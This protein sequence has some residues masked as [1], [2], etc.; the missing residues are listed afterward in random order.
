MYQ[1]PWLQVPSPAEVCQ[2][3][4]LYPDPKTII[5]EILQPV[6]KTDPRSK[7]RITSE[8]FLGGRLWKVHLHFQWPQKF[9]V[10]GQGDHCGRAIHYAYLSACQMFMHL[11]LLTG[12]G[13]MIDYKETLLEIQKMFKNDTVNHIIEF[14]SKHEVF[15]NGDQSMWTTEI[16]VNSPV[17]VGVSAK[18]VTQGIAEQ[19]A[20][21]LMII[22]LRAM[23]LLD[24]QSKLPNHNILWT[25]PFHS[26]QQPFVP[27]FE[28]YVDA[29]SRGYGAYLLARG[30]KFDGSVR[31]IQE[32]W[33]EEMRDEYKLHSTF[34]EFYGILE[35]VYTWKKKFEGCNVLCW[36]DNQQA[37]N[38]I[39]KGLLVRAR[40]GRNLL[41]MFKV[42]RMTC[43]K[44]KVNL[45]AQHIYR[46]DNV[47][48]D[49][50][51]KQDI[52]TFIEM[53]PN[54]SL[55]SKKSKKMLFFLPL[56]EPTPQTIDTTKTV[57]HSKEDSRIT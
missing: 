20:A 55:K 27:D 46:L 56:S 14:R 39:N 52:E 41:K 31:W 13:K 8:R 6:V 40:K 29:S 1:K 32:Q 24:R 5:G 50:L 15:A 10:C 28:V 7:P 2:Y 4:Q 47:A 12:D 43:L 45:R 25:L 26:K 36:C 16:E 44:Y 18:G 51:S 21:A 35:T 48:A 57:E 9:Q 11:G 22:K 37:V 34:L 38:F 17:V 42:L 30:D 54:A 53:F 23:K 19:T 33:S 3:N 49:R